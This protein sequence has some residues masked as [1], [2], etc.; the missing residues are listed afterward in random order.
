MVKCRIWI[1][2]DKICDEVVRSVQENTE[3]YENLSAKYVILL[4][5]DKSTSIVKG[6]IK[7][8]G[9]KLI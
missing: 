4:D 3:F 6:L 8:K 9:V 7:S 1:I 5:C 2:D